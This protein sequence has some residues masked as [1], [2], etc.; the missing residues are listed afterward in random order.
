MLVTLGYLVHKYLYAMAAFELSFSSDKALYDIMASN[1]R[2]GIMPKL[3]AWAFFYITFWCVNIWAADSDAMNIA[4]ATV[5]EPESA[6][7]ELAA[8][9]KRLAEHKSEAQ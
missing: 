6:L 4:N 3:V 1:L 2:E 8:A 9:T 7:K 5:G